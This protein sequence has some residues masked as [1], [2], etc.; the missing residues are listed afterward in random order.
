MGGDLIWGVQQG[1][2]KLRTLT[3]ERVAYA[4]VVHGLLATYEVKMKRGHLPAEL[5]KCPLC[6]HT[7][8]TNSHFLLSCTHGG[9]A[10]IRAK[11]KKEVAETFIEAEALDL[12]WLCATP[13]LHG[14]RKGWSA[15]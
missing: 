2:A 7:N 1:L 6:G 11:W 8:E 14:D 3:H 13:H 4:K 9:V 12:G 5:N 15:K 10:K